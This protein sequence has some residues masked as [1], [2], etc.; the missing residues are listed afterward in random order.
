MW[1][2]GSSDIKGSSM[3]SWNTFIFKAVVDCHPRSRPWDVS[4]GLSAAGL[5]V[6]AKLSTQLHKRLCNQWLRAGSSISYKAPIHWSQISTSELRVNES[7]CCLCAYSVL[8][9]SLLVPPIEMNEKGACIKKQK[10]VIFDLFIMKPFDEWMAIK[11]ATCIVLKQVNA[12]QSLCSRGRYDR[13]WKT[14]LKRAFFLLSDILTFN[15]TK[16]NHLI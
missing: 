12:V 14:L 15:H 3:A 16:I 4:S 11:F 7:V 1:N 6:S 10:N 2:R 13:V 5:A 8:E 9:K